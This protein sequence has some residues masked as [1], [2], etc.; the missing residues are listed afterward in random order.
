M[1]CVDCHN[2]A[3]HIYK[4]PEDIVDE[5]I[6]LG[7]IDRELPYI[8]REALAAITK[9]YPSQKAAQNGIANQIYNFYKRSCPEIRPAKNR[10]LDRAV[11]VLQ[12]AYATYRHHHMRIE[13]NTYISHIGHKQDLG[14]FRCHNADMKTEDGETIGHDCT[15]CH[16]ILAMDSAEPYQFLRDAKEDAPDRKM[17]DYLQKEFFQ[18]K[19]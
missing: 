15:M 2:R 11:Q 13:W 1:D 6:R 12:E 9:G 3:T 17:H 19:Y 10:D 4:A 8:K 7:E 14:C 18:T 16:S 5:L